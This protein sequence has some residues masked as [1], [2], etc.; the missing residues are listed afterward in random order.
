VQISA[1]QATNPSPCDA[2]LLAKLDVPRDTT[3]TS[4]QLVAS[5]AT[6]PEFC[7]VLGVI[8]PVPD[9]RIRFVVNL[10]TQWNGRF[11]HIGDGGYDG[12]VSTSTERLAQGYATTN[13]DMGYDAATTKPTAG[14]F[15]FNNR[16]AEIDY[17]Y[18]AVHET[19]RAAKRIIRSYYGAP[20]VYSYFDGCSTGGRE[21]LMEAQRYPFDFDGIV[22][23]AP[24][25][26]LTGLAI[27]QNWSLQQLFRNNFANNIVGKTQ[28]LA[29]AVKDK[30]DAIDGLKDGLIDDPRRC[31]FDPASL[32]CKPGQDPASCLTEGQVGAV[33]S[34][35]QGPRNS[36]GFSY[37]GKPAGSEFWWSL[38][39][40]P[41][42]LPPAQGGNN[43]APAQGGFTFDF[44]NYLFF[45][46]D[47]GPSFD[48]QNFDFETDPAKRG[49]MSRILN[50]TDEDLTPFRA[51]GGK[52]ILYHGWADGLIPPF[53]TVEYYRDVVKRERS[54]ERTKS[55]ARLFMVPGMDHC[56]F[57]PGGLRAWD[58]LAPLIAWVEQGIA[59][60]QIVATET[61]GT[62]KPLRTRPLC[63]YPQ[64]ARWTGAGSPDE[65]TNFQ[66]VRPPTRHGW[67]D[68]LDGDDE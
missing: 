60:A 61:D 11:V 3:L 2:T 13:S 22:A 20:I 48:W 64:V 62:G 14:A 50:A 34:I 19:T 9:S 4:A 21:G 12:T 18:R 43:N 40:V 49:F 17:G 38:W 68:D 31:D 29:D 46:D 25:H 24:A 42:P 41:N 55:F 67:R 27:E 59:P 65:G 39:I 44:M 37:R 30:C 66:C 33:R 53:R 56:G 28:L 63:P 58:R 54:L 23:G 32:R 10:P 51:K 52:L 8:S 35:Y 7:K 16:V 47:P 15:A 5:T 6:V 1:A 36:S 45:R 57:V 26:D